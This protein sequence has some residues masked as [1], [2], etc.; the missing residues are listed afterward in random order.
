MIIKTTPGPLIL[1]AGAVWDC[2]T[3][4]STMYKFRSMDRAERCSEEKKQAWTTRDDP[5]K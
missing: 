4:R 1:Q 3:S 2:R 5:R